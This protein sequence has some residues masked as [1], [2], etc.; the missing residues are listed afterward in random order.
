MWTLSRSIRRISSFSMICDPLSRISI[1]INTIGGPQSGIRSSSA[2][3]HR[4]HERSC[5]YIDHKIRIL[6]TY[7]KAQ[8]PL[9]I[10]DHPPI[11]FLFA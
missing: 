1:S 7:S 10:F 5:E 11:G 8:D 4:H 2:D 6:L 3:E 9:K